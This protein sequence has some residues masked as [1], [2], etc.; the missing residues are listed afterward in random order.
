LELL[1]LAEFVEILPLELQIEQITEPKLR[2]HSLTLNLL[3][4]IEVFAAEELEVELHLQQL[5]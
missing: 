1:V 4:K 2:L 3:V 5:G